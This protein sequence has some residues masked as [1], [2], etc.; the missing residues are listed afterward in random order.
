MCEIELS[1][2]GVN[3]QDPVPLYVMEYEWGGGD[4]WLSV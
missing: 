1:E 2:G 4:V 3:I